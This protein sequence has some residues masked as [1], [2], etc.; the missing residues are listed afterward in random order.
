MIDGRKLRPLFLS[1]LKEFDEHPDLKHGLKPYQAVGWLLGFIILKNKHHKFQFG[2][3]EADELCYF[4]ALAE[5]RYY[6]KTK[7]QKGNAK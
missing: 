2:Q 1:T 7:Q 3:D 5:E 4:I 6:G